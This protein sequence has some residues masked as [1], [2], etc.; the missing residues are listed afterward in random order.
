MKRYFLPMKKKEL[1]TF[2]KNTETRICNRFI[3][4]DY[5]ITSD[6]TYPNQ[7]IALTANLSGVATVAKSGEH[8]IGLYTSKGYKNY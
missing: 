5:R 6:N 4:D 8:H 7:F 1:E 3:I 2:K